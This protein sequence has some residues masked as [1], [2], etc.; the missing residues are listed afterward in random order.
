MSAVNQLL[1]AGSNSV[2]KYSFIDADT[3]VDPDDSNIKYRLQG[4]D[5]PEIMKFSESG[6]QFSSG[7]AGG[8]QATSAITNLAEKQGFTNLVKTGKQD[9]NGREIV[10]LHND[11]G[12]NFTTE[13]FR[14]GI[15][16][17]GKY[18][19]QEDIDAA[20]VAELFGRS[21]LSDDPDWNQ[22][23]VLVTDAIRA[24]SAQDLSFKEQALNELY[25]NPA[26]HS[27]AVQFRHTDRDLNNKALSPFSDS[28]EQGWIGVKE[29]AWG[30]LNMLGETTGMEGLADIG[31][32]GRERARL[33]LKEYGTTITDYKDVKGFWD[34]IEY[35]SNNAAISLPYMAITTGGAIAAPFT[36]GLS[37]TAP[38][39]VYSGQVWN[40]QEGDN[41]NAALAVGAG[42]AQAALDRLGLSFIFKAGK[43]PAKML[44]EATENL[45]AGGMA[46]DVAEKTVMNATRKEIAGFVGDAAKVA[47]QQITGKAI[48]K[49][50]SKRGLAGGLGETATEGLQEAIGYTAAHTANGFADFDFNDLNDRLINAAIAGGTLGT[51]FSVPASA[52]NTGAWADIAFREAEATQDT[53][54]QAGRF[55]EQE[56]A[57]YGRVASVQELTEEARNR[58][59][60]EGDTYSTLDEKADVEAKRRK[61]RTFNEALTETMLSAPALWRGATRYIFTPA[62]QAQSRAARILADMFGANLQKTF[63]GS[64]FENTKHHRVSEYKGMIDTP[65]SVWNKLN[66]GRKANSKKRGELSDKLYTDMRNAINPATKKFA[67]ALQISDG[68]IG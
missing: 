35:I 14:S 55:A 11:K 47:S 41:K 49:D 67:G 63:S 7:T 65:N 44:Q 61:D 57:N 17:P 28:W 43:A 45:I 20:K 54:S 6:E 68:E 58:V 34:A 22:A 25:Y 62:I 4:F 5:A 53:L 1:D 48:F 2:G 51:A 60:A 18:T 15:L 9:P 40:E 46:K 10:E 3:L 13:I 29:A 56:E 39:A 27:S 37:L 19:K 24:E 26:F 32:N 21:E 52:F 64:N 33:Q 8:A 66:R 31:E 50:L 38:A 42:V 12:Q 59:A 36:G 30:V 23:A 16:D